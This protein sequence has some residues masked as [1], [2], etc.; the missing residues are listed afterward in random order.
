MRL[1]SRIGQGRWSSLAGHIRIWSGAPWVLMLVLEREVVMVTNEP[2][3]RPRPRALVVYESMFGNT[4]AIAQAIVD[5]LTTGVEAQITEVSW[6]PDE[7][8]DIDLLVVGAPTRAFGL[9]RT[10]TREELWRR[11]ARIEA[12]GADGV[13]EWIAGIG[14]GSVGTTSAVAF[15]TRVRRPR[16][17]RSAARAARRRLRR[18]GFRVGQ[19]MSFWVVGTR[20]PLV[21]GELDRARHWGEQLAITCSQRSTQDV[22]GSSPMRANLGGRR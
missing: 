19:A 12:A 18:V 13:R 5:G 7:L 10:Q 1:G 22:G 8:G 21:D 17:T 6:A 14:A 15:D 9:R 4:A 2:D 20:G 3:D 11:G 16:L